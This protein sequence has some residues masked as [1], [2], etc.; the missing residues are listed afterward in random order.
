MSNKK[1]HDLIAKLQE[2]ADLD[3]TEVGYTSQALIDMTDHNL[4]LSSEFYAVLIA[5][6]QKQLDMFQEQT[7]II[8]V[9]RKQISYVHYELEWKT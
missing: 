3:N 2:Y 4:Y 8:K 1:P 7:K 5:E 6:I 9:E